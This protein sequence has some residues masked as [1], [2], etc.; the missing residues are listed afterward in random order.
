MREVSDESSLEE[1]L[2]E[3]WYLRRDGKELVESYPSIKKMA[4][5]N[6]EGKR[7]WSPAT[8]NGDIQGIRKFVK[9][10]DELGTRIVLNKIIRGELNAVK[11]VTE[12]GVGF[13]DTMLKKYAY[14]T[15]HAR[16]KIFLLIIFRALEVR[17]KTWLRLCNI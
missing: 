16:R 11:A 1:F 5:S 2:K 12:E 4:L 8:V 15:V 14:K 10:L 13:I 6:V 3:I 9:F 17:I 7:R